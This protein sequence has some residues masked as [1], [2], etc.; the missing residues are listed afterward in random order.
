MFETDTKNQKI[1]I[2]TLTAQDQV[3]PI[4]FLNSLNPSC[5]PPYKLDLKIGT[6]IILCEI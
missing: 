1:T 6:P 4:E 3:I 5:L 2:D